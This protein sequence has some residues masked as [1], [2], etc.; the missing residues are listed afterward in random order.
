[1]LASYRKT[2]RIMVMSE[3]YK[4][5]II[6]GSWVFEG[7]SCRIRKDRVV[8]PIG[9]ET[10]YFVIH[11]NRPAVSILAT[12]DGD[13]TLLV[14]QWRHTVQKLVWGTPAG[15]VEEGEQPIDAAVREL[16]EETGCVAKQIAP[17]YWVHPSVGIAR[18]T[19]HL[20]HATGCEQ[21]TERLPGE[22]HEAQWFSRAEVRQMLK[23]NEILDALG[24]MS[25][26]FWLAS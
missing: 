12:D 8:D 26:L 13:R 5:Q 25:L 18:Q 6:D 19:Y 11:H 22:I 10:D 14:Q 23:Q 17:V 1:M 7:W 4:W 3:S 16:R 21:R 20:F 24:V 2:S 15:G 9:H